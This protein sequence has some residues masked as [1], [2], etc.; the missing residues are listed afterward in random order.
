[1]CTLKQL[2][3]STICLARWL[4]HSVRLAKIIGAQRSVLID[5][6]TNIA[7]KYGHNNSVF[8]AENNYR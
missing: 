2:L 8:T 6:I 1:M 7:N 3:S 5:S 4:F